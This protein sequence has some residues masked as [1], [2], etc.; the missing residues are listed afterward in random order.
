M[1]KHFTP[2]LFVL[3]STMMFAQITFVHRAGS[4]YS[5]YATSCAP[6]SDGGII[7]SQESC[8]NG[9]D[10]HSSLIK[11]D[12]FGI[13]QWYNNYRIGGYTLPMTV[14]E[15]KDGGYIVLAMASDSS[16]INNNNYF[17]A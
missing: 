15:G 5:D 3:F 6:T 13:M 17:L 7:L 11:T 1:I 8:T 4:N 12:A 9:M 14:L 2:L 16:Y 10:L